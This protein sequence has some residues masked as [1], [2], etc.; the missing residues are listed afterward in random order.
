MKICR[1]TSWDGN[2]PAYAD[3]KQTTGVAVRAESE[4]TIAGGHKVIVNV[5]PKNFKEIT[6]ELRQRF[7]VTG[8]GVLR[9]G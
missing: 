5:M 2:V 1:T 9:F 6:N 7:G 4:I 8:W 3:N